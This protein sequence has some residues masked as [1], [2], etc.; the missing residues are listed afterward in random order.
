[1]IIT[2]IILTIIATA[3]TYW[4]QL[5]NGEIRLAPLV[6]IMVGALWS[7]MEIEDEEVTEYWLQICI[8]FI[9]ITVIW[10]KPMTGL[11]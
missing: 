9:S 3:A 5:N 7:K 4:G 1:M 6:G 11:K 2:L 8:V 10:E